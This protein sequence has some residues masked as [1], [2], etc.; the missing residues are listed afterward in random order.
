[1]RV[2]RAVLKLAGCST[3]TL[4]RDV[5]VQQAQTNATATVA[6]TEADVQV[7][8]R[9]DSSSTVDIAAQDSRGIDVEPK[10]TEES[11]ALQ[12]TLL[13]VVH[14]ATGRHCYC[15]C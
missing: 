14:L 4:S 11:L 2:S 3:M 6:E 5:S 10:P 15:C 7:E 8:R 13:A 1:M 12:S 9:T